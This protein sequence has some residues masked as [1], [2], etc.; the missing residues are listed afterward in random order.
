MGIVQLFSDGVEEREGGPS[1]NEVLVVVEVVA[2]TVANLLEASLV[3]EAARVARRLGH[4][5]SVLKMRLLLHLAD[6]R[7]GCI[8][9]TVVERI[10]FLGDLKPEDGVADEC[11]N[12]DEGTHEA[13]DLRSLQLEMH[14]RTGIRK[15][16][17]QVLINVACRVCEV[18]SK[19][20]GVHVVVMNK[21]SSVQ[22]FRT[23]IEAHIVPVCGPNL[24]V[25]M[26]SVPEVFRQGQRQ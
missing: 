7:G 20:V 3:D 15:L 14:R 4:A 17:V 8:L 1:A 26:L 9:L 22:S 21:A 16:K 13:S 19:V 12:K 11:A 10:V 5:R 18:V 2:N 25:R 23:K 6:R 24:V